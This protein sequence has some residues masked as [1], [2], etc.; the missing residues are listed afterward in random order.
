MGNIKE[1]LEII[2]EEYKGLGCGLDY[3]SPYQLLIA[4]IL[5][6]QC[7]DKRVNIITE[8]LFKEYGT[9]EKMIL[10]DQV[11][12]G[13]KIKSCGLYH[14]KSKNILKTTEDII[15]KYGGEV[16]STIEELM[17]LSGVGRKTANVVLYNAFNI[18]AMAVDT[19]V[20][21]VANRLGIGKGKDVFQVE[22][23]LMKVID[24]EKLGEF[25][26]YLIWHGRTLCL[27]RNPKCQLCKVS[28][29]CEYNISTK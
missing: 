9:P 28:K 18:P 11:N 6:A 19:H 1:I 16:P 15:K 4:T 23:N 29:Y 7:T 17:E 26:H 10:L 21:R 27:A 25:H 20:F 13:E 2:G 8:E 22:K 5:S 12:L 3:K 14:S 24:S